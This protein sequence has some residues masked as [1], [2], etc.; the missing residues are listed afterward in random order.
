MRITLVHAG[1]FGDTLLLAPLLRSLKQLRPDAAITVVMRPE[2]GRLLVQLK[3]ADSW[4]D[5]DSPVHSLWFTPAEA[6]PD[7]QSPAYPSWADCSLL[8]SAVSNGHDN[9]ADH[10][11]LLPAKPRVC[12]FDPRPS[13]QSKLPVTEFHRRQLSEL[14]LPDAPLPMARFNP[15]G[16]IIIAPGAGSRQKCLPLEKFLYMAGKIKSHGG[17]VRFLLRPAELD[18]F[19]NFERNTIRDSFDIY[20]CDKVA[21]LADLLH[22]AAGFIGND[23]G[24]GHLAAAMGIPTLIWFVITNPEQWAPIGPQVR[25]VR[26]DGPALQDSVIENG[27]RWLLAQASGR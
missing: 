16:A 7:S 20:I 9:W 21:R 14:N 24:P 2:F 3:L 19:S 22:S 6:G 15:E 26:G 10:A 8:I 5:G 4:A 13:E 17:A 11:R 18:R 12:F 27:L 1:A 25:V 23:S